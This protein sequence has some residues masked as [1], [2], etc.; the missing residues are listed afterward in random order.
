ME[1]WKSNC[2]YFYKSVGN[3][4]N[5]N[6]EINRIASKYKDDTP[7]EKMSF[8]DADHLL[9]MAEKLGV[10]IREL[11]DEYPFEQ[12]IEDV[13]YK[14]VTPDYPI[15]VS[16]ENNILRV[17]TPTTFKRMFRD[18]SLKENYVLMRYVKNAIYT[19]QQNEGIDIKHK[20]EL[21][22]TMLLVRRSLKF[23]QSIICDNDNLENGRIINEIMKVLG[24]NDSPKEL[25]LHCCYRTCEKKEDVGMEFI[26]GNQKDILE[27][28]SNNFQ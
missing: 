13:T 17:K 9:F 19:F 26:V 27:L 15:K 23:S 10:S 6:K 12:G 4:K 21:P 22:L 2:D 20:L 28:L 14:F 7:I 5:L 3:I 24:Y 18:N 8:N 11:V 25:D 16:F 1:N